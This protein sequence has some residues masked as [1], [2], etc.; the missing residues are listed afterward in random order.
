[1]RPAP[2]E[3]FLGNWRRRAADLL[4]EIPYRTA[5]REA[6]ALV[7][8]LVEH[9]T[10][11]DW[12]I[13]LKTFVYAAL[14]WEWQWRTWEEAR[15]PRPDLALTPVLPIVLHTGPRPWGSARTLRELLGPPAAFHAFVPDWRPL[16][17]ELAT[18]APEELLSGR[19]AFLQ[20]LTILKADDREP[21]EAEQ[22]FAAVFRQLDPLHETGRVRWRELLG[23]L[24]GWALH[25]RPKAE[26]PHWQSVAVQLQQ[27]AERQREIEAMGQTIAQSLIEEGLQ[28]GLQEGQVQHARRTLIRF[29]SR[30]F[31]TPPESVRQTIE[32]IT[33]LDRLDRL[34]DQVGQAFSWPELLATN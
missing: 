11:T 34:T 28:K 15:P 12:Q 6:F 9:Q 7:C 31:G 16:F 32:Q 26:R 17:W 21:A 3:F 27:T 4:F 13:P 33:D 22:L 14:Y 23:F 24:L 20:A 10:R 1:M 30:K 25:R 29:G 8:V 5:E 2:R 18:H 19:A